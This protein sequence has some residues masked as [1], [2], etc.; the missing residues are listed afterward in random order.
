MILYMYIYL[1]T[2]IYISNISQ[3]TGTSERLI[4]QVFRFYNPAIIPSLGKMEPVNV[5]LGLSMLHYLNLDA[6]LGVITLFMLE[7]YVS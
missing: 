3:Q 1:D 4:R 5:T 6:D 7:R 2:N